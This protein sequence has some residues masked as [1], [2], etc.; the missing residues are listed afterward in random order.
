MTFKHTNFEDS[1][2]M[3]SLVKLAKEKGLI[4]E[5]PLQKIASRKPKLDLKPTK[6]L[7]EN[8]MKL[9]SGLR[10]TGMDKYADELELTFLQYKQAAASEC[11]SDLI[12]Q[13]HPK[14][15]YK[16]E[17]V[18]GDAIIETI[19]DEHLKLMKIVEKMPTGKLTNAKSII[20]AVK[21]SLGE[22]DQIIQLQQKIA[23]LL[24]RVISIMTSFANQA[25]SDLWLGGGFG[26]T[27]A[28]FVE[29]AKENPTTEKLN[30]ISSR[31]DTLA[32]KA[33]PEYWGTM[34]V[35]ESTWNKIKGLPSLAKQS[36]NRAT[37][38]MDQINAIRQREIEAPFQES[39]PEETGKTETLEEVSIVGAPEFGALRDKIRILI[40]K[41][42]SW[43]AVVSTYDDTGDVNTGNEYIANTIA[44]L[45]NINSAMDNVDPEYAEGVVAKLT[46]GFEAIE[47]DANEFYRDWIA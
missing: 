28:S 27:F 20:S 38:F 10:A 15:S 37:Q 42:N 3:R 2:T 1:E 22:S 30:E 7:S 34:G 35:D 4:K 47:T 8:L 14:G 24:Q 12:Q 25:K 41:L 18:E 11:D 26:S 9:C 31:I 44:K 45:R 40:G 43:K 16:L 5:D 13:A 32:G 23:A 46:S 21:I 33:E 39:T 6:S 29:D 17:G 19:I 36:I